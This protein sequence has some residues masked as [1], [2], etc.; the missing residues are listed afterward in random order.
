[1]SAG[2]TARETARE[3]ARRTRIVDVALLVKRGKIFLLSV[4]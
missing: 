3:T 1:M 2:K 4:Y